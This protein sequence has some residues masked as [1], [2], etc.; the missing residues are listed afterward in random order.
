MSL[1]ISYWA[2]IPEIV[3]SLAGIV[4]MLLAPIVEP[5]SR[6]RLGY[7]AFIGTV[8]AGAATAPL[9][10]K[11]MVAF[12]GMI[13]VDNYG[14]FLRLIFILI[15]ALSI[16]LS[17]HFNRREEINHGEYFALI[18][19][20]TA[21]MSLM[22]AGTDLI[23]IFLGLEIL[24]IATYVLAGFKRSDVKSNE[25]SLKYFLLGSF[26]TAFLLYGI[27]FAY[28]A[29]GST[30]LQNI[31]QALGA[32]TQ[33]TRLLGPQTNTLLL[34]S[35][36]LLIAGFGFKVATVPFHIW[37]PDV[38]E[39]AP[40]PVTTFMAVGP[41]A[42]GFAAF[43]RLLLTAMPA[44]HWYWAG[45]L[46]I[47][48]ALTMTLGNV[49][50]LVQPNLKRMLAYSSIAHAGYILIGMAAGRELNASPILFYILAYTLMSVGAFA[51]VL[52]VSGKGDLRVNLDDYA[53]L[54][55]QQPVLSFAL[56]LC[57]LSLAG[58]PLTA[59]F[60]G[61]FYLFTTAVQAGYV[62][63]VI[64]AALNSVVSVFYY[65][66]PVIYMFMRESTSPAPEISVPVPVI[67]T[68]IITTIG[69]LWLG[70]FP[71]GFIQL[72]KESL[73]ALK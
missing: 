50:A 42:A 72:A 19:F 45:I 25:S 12:N 41:K 13:T 7:L 57:L 62:G 51:V 21:G 28:G 40:T 30:N 61:K 37:T 27:A 49:V 8:L 60:M 22:A 4:I 59:G 71:A 33:G 53:G 11:S 39:G 47:L 34:L 69:T 26:S 32:A 9:W 29:T 73:L 43:L 35:L 5:E 14:T 44:Y 6:G 67:I 36:A 1:E 52:T 15:A 58:I 24:S 65:V 31:R 63:L 48:A 55:F 38:Y 46:W 64:I 56:S 17:V 18:L 20:A 68:L 2:V 54:G 66:R 16:L 70:I 3:L 23:I 10:N